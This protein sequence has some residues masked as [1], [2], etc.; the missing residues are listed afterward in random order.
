MIKRGLFYL[1]V[2]LLIS[3]LSA[4]CVNPFM[5]QILDPKTVAFD[6]NGGSN[7]A[8]QTVFKGQTV[9]RPSDPSKQDFVFE[10][11]Y[12]DNE[13]FENQWNFNSIPTANITLYANWTPV[14]QAPADISLTFEQIAEGA[15]LFDDITIS[16]SGED[17]PQ[18]F[19]V[20]IEDFSVYDSVK[21]EIFGAGVSEDVSIENTGT[22]T[23]DAADER[24]NSLG[25]HTLRLTVVIDTVPYMVNINFKVVE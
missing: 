25:G 9:K 23:L 18:T 17:Y 21:W 15:P 13:T 24:Y 4:G 22:F 10:G 2:C 19:V 7:V 11:W 14:V 12:R 6:T 3:A 1:A 8:N 20:E 16:R 5:E